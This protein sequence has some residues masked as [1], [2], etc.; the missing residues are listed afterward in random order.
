MD[1]HED[2]YWIQC[3]RL[4]TKRHK[5][6]MQREHADKQLIRKHKEEKAI[7]Q[8][9][10][11][12]GWTELKPPV[13]RGFIR[14]FILRD[15][16]VRTKE[17]PFFQKILD[18][19]NSKQL[20]HRR[21]FKKKRRR[22]GK[23]VYVVREQQLTDMSEYDFTKKF[24][25]KEKLYFY[26]TLVHYGKSKIPSKVYRFLEPWRFVLKV[27]PNMITR[28]RV[29]DFDLERQRD[30]VKRFFN[31]KRR[32]RLS[33]LLHGSD[34]WGWNSLPKGKYDDPFLNKS[35]A[36]ILDE[37]WLDKQLSITFKNPRKTGG[38]SF[39]TPYSPIFFWLT[40]LVC[41]GINKETTT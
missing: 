4:R 19:I 16:V 27:Q 7:W 20:S 32:L 1:T 8:A 14:F 11:N 22:F 41:C 23:K 10:R 37:H 39:F 24:A 6:R 5:K 26:E 31:F 21:D 30:E 35:F 34:R 17:A 36:S 15:D 40:P 3:T 33:K 12:L 13:Q 2:S 29:K 25:D 18:K 38:F 9:M 28:V